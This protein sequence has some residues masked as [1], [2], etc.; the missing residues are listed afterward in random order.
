MGGT[1]A[2]KRKQVGKTE[3]W[4]VGESCGRGA[5]PH[6]GNMSS[7][8]PWQEGP[9]QEALCHWDK[10]VPG[11]LGREERAGGGRGELYDRPPPLLLGLVEEITPAPY[12]VTLQRVL[13]QA[14]LTHGTSHLNAEG[15]ARVPPWPVCQGWVCEHLGA[16]IRHPHLPAAPTLSS[17]THLWDPLS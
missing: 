2:S 13:R 1:E 16:G 15:G 8:G 9:G 3:G 6:E 4:G 5:S 12:L 14:L 10:L 17:G 7:L 11:L